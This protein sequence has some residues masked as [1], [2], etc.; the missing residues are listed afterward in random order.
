MEQDDELVVDATLSATE[1]GLDF[2]V[3][4]ANGN[5]SNAGFEFINSEDGENGICIY[6]F[7]EEYKF[8]TQAL[9]NGLKVTLTENAV[10]EITSTSAN[11]LVINVDITDLSIYENYYEKCYIAFDGAIIIKLA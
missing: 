10:L 7:G 3:T 1:N 4:D 6:W 2:E 8:T 9:E 5:S 11:E